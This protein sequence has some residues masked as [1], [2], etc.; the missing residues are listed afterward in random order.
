[1]QKIRKQ[2]RKNGN[3]E[4]TDRIIYYQSLFNV[5]EV[6]KTKII[7]RYHNNLLAEYF[8]IKKT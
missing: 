6:V 1:M 5:H 4:S 2:G 7:S 3:E 8:K